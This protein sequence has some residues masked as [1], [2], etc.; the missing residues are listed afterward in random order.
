MVGQKTDPRD[1][2]NTRIQKHNPNKDGFDQNLEPE[3]ELLWKG[4]IYKFYKI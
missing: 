2:V 1:K 3:F 4:P